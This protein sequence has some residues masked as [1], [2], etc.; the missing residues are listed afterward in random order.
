M[1]SSLLW[2]YIKDGSGER[3]DK[4]MVIVLLVHSIEFPTVQNKIYVNIS[5]LLLRL[6]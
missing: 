3:A 1:S 5:Q 4:S 6:P 2:S